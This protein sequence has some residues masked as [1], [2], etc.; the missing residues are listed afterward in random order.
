MRFAK[1]VFSFI[2]VAELLSGCSLFLDERESFSSIRGVCELAYAW[3][4]SESNPAEFR[5][6]LIP[7]K[8]ADA[9]Q[10]F[11][12]NLKGK[13]LQVY[14]LNREYTKNRKERFGGLAYG[15]FGLTM[16]R[17]NL[18]LKSWLA[19][20]PKWSVPKISGMF[21]TIQMKD[22]K[23][24]AAGPNSVTTQ[25]TLLFYLERQKTSWVICDV[26]IKDSVHDTNLVDILT[27]TLTLLENDLKGL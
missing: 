26:E 13:L 2:L 11:S 9:P 10:I 4:I 7:A 25:R 12:A 23:T 1:F 22:V 17:L 21:A 8:L 6:D 5:A 15:N 18:P 27:G 20:D 24:Y 16:M 14:H 19:R 3:N